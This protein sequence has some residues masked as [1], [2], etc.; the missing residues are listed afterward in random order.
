MLTMATVADELATALTLHRRGERQQ[1]E[2]A[3]NRILRIDP[4]H[5]DALHLL[6]VIAQQNGDARRA[7]EH[8]ARAIA[9]Q[10]QSAVFHNNLGAALLDQGRHGEAAGS[11][12]RALALQPNYL[13]ALLNLA[14]AASQGDEL[15]VAVDCWQ[16]SLRLKPDNADALQSLGRLPEAIEYYDRVLKLNPD[17]SEAHNNR[18]VA[19]LNLGDSDEA[20][21]SFERAVAINPAYADAL[22]NLGVANF[23]QGNANE[24]VA[25][26]QRVIA[27]NPEDVAAHTGMGDALKSLGRLDAAAKAYRSALG[28]D[29]SL[30]ELHNTLGLCLHECGQTDEAVVCFQRAVK[31]DPNRTDGHENLGAA[32]LAEGH[33]EDAL[34]CFEQA[35]GIDPAYVDARFNR[36]LARLLSGDWERG[37]ADYESRRQLGRINVRD[38][39]QPTW[40]GSPLNGRSILLHA[41]QGLGDTLQ[42]VRYVS[43]VRQQASQPGGRVLLL[44]PRPL[45]SLLKMTDGFDCIAS[46]VDSLPPFDVHA[47]LMSLP[48]ILHTTLDSVPAAV[49]YLAANTE[50]ITVWRE[51]L[52]SVRRFR[53]GINWQGDPNNPLD[54]A[55]SISLMQFA[56]LADVAGVSLISLQKGTGA[57]QL[58][59]TASQFD[60]VHLGDDVDETVGAFMDTAAIMQS[61]DLVITSDTSIAHLAGGLGVPVWVALAFVPEW[62]WLLQR[63]DSPWY[64]TMRL[65]RQPQPNDWPGLFAD[66]QTALSRL[67][68]GA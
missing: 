60:V 47:P 61:L 53:V 19:L 54:R 14:R 30:S 22:R 25:A 17:R 16:R 41:E 40:D 13:D 2:R 65:F 26:Y 1:A 10:P 8:I 35:L 36:G 67:V 7:I 21:A 24:A 11:F 15:T 6:G 52:P 46:D 55:R 66:M 31:C 50:L 20:I 32:L 12:R 23:Q 33:I 37:W 34:G 62:R 28:I 3:Y 48:G 68:G 57:E 4:Q 27:L 59:E 39:P 45:L 58:A 43:L 42:F 64:P 38:F 5:A 56:P 9:V 29:G 51:R 63:D 49:P 18:G 44:A